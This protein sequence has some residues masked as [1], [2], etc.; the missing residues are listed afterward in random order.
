M[1][2]HFLYLVKIMRSF[3]PELV[4]VK[5]CNT[6]QIT[7]KKLGHFVLVEKIGIYKME[8]FCQAIKACSC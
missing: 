5:V 2:G 8:I 3:T 1:L 7:S 6:V 4:N